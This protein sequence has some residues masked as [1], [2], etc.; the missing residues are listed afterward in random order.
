MTPIYIVPE[1]QGAALAEARQGLTLNSSGPRSR[2][3]VEIDARREEAA[4]FLHLL[5]S[6]RL[7]YVLVAPLA[8]EYFGGLRA[9]VSQWPVLL[10][11]AGFQAFATC[12]QGTSSR[13]PA[14]SR[15]MTGSSTAFSALLS[16]AFA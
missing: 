13:S 9:F 14:D 5:A 4:R 16:H 3:V 12:L 6:S 7:R 1:V 2:P 8:S 11:P 10:A 15:R